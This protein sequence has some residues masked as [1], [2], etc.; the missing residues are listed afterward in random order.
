MN[1]RPGYRTFARA[2]LY[3][4]LAVLWVTVIRPAH[5]DML[6]SETTL[7]SGTDSSVA[8]FTVTGAESVTVQLSNIAWPQ[9]LSSLSFML[10]SADEVIGSWSSTDSS[11]VETYQLSPGTYYAHITGTAS[12]SLDLGLYS[13]SIGTQPAPVPLPPGGALLLGGLL[14]L[15]MSGGLLRSGVFGA[16][17]AVTSA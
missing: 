3:A 13:L 8:S 9:M 12:G 10:S 4:S 2:V 16:R 7:V 17:A 5:A 11:T 6:V 14:V 1:A 15:M